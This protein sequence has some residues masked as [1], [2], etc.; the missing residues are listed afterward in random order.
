[1]KKYICDA[2][3]WIYDPAIGVP[4][5]GIAPG[6]AFEDLPDDFLCPECGVDK[7]NFSVVED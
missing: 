4:D 6:I 3:A 1:M 5:E 2:C 7:E